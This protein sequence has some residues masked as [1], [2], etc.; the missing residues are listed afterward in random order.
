MSTDTARRDTTTDGGRP[1]PSE[2]PTS[3]GTS[4]PI[5][6]TRRRIDLVLIA[7]GVLAAVVFA[8]A[9]ALLTWGSGFS[10]DYVHDELTSQNI[11]FPPAEALEAEGRDDLLEYA[12]Q[13]LE[14]GDQAEAYA[15]YINGH[16]EHTADGLTYAELSGPEREANAA[17]QEAIDSGADQATIDEL[18]AE[19]TTIS[20]QRNTLFKGET[21]RGLLLSAYAWATVG[22]IA[23]Y[24]AIGAYVAAVA[25][26]ILVIFGIVHLR[27]R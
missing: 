6:L 1:S 20:E 25:M 22:K 16:L 14:T 9:G 7:F 4:H 21:L 12:G 3:N 26:A 11:T 23:G 18:Q 8:V 19:A 10:D 24:A 17:V 13:P 27:K 5:T 2:I 15:S